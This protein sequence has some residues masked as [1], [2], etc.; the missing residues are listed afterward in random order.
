SP[1]GP[2]R[3]AGGRKLAGLPHVWDPTPLHMTS[4]PASAPAAKGSPGGSAGA[5]QVVLG[6]SP[7]D[8][9]DSPAGSSPNPERGSVDSRV[10]ANLRLNAA[11]LHTAHSHAR[12]RM[13]RHEEW[14]SE[15]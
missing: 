6:L 13:A 2:G 14:G 9:G 12:P 10:V 7:L 15:R 11:E 3:E 1:N 8:D 5:S 4:E